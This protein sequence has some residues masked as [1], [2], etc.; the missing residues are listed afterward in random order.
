MLKICFFVPES[1][2]ELVK[3]A[4]FN[5]GAGHIGAYDQCCWQTLG[6]GQFR[7]L[8]G[9]D[10]FL[11]AAGELEHVAEYKVEMVCSEKAI[12]EVVA[13]LRAT[14]PYEEPAFEVHN[15]VDVMS[16]TDLPR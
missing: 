11:G 13:I 10:P 7:P 16:A 12:V 8:P 6:Q 9:S 3:S 14:H 5:A 2:L 15:L 4:M 1:H